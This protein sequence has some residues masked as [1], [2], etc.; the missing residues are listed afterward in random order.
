[1]DWRFGVGDGGI[2]VPRR[3]GAGLAAAR[4][5]CSLVLQQCEQTGLSAL[6]TYVLLLAALGFGCLCYGFLH[7]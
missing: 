5:H 1:M 3:H 7:V 2:S 4:L 6:C